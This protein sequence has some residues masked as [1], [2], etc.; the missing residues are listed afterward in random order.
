[1]NVDF[2]HLFSS[3]V[4]VCNKLNTYFSMNTSQR[5]GDWGKVKFNVSWQICNKEIKLEYTLLLGSRLQNPL[6]IKAAVLIGQVT[7]KP[8]INSTYLH[9]FG[10]FCKQSIVNK[11]GE[12]GTSAYFNFIGSDTA[13]VCALYSVRC[14]LWRHA[15]ERS[16][17]SY[18]RM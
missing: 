3:T 2:N 10:R 5:K 18:L 8:N 9:Q 17:A 1:M 16:G 7:S 12:S 11:S 15:C 14:T 13:I 6:Y 4:F